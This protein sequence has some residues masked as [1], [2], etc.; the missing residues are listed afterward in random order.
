MAPVELPETRQGKVTDYLANERTFLA[1]VRTAVTIIA[2]GF[3]IVKFG[4]L[5]RELRGGGQSGARL[6]APIGIALVALGGALVVLALQRTRR[7]EV[8]ITA[9]TYH[10]DPLLTT[11]LT[12]GI[13][14]VSLLLAAYLAA[15]G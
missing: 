11:A 8:D 5:T 9:G 6:S 15:S 10:P 4:L 3:V 14:L 7:A 13:V 1:W 12:A 2:L